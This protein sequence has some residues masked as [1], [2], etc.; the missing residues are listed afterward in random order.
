MNLEEETKKTKRKMIIITLIVVFGFLFF[1]IILPLCL[2]DAFFTTSEKYYILNITE[3]NEEKVRS[4]IAQ[5][6][7]NIGIKQETIDTCQ[8]KKIE[9]FHMFPDGTH[10][11]LFCK[12]QVEVSF[13]I[14]KVGEDVLQ[15]YIREHGTTEIRKRKLHSI[16][17]L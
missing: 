1:L 17:F 9:F 5:E 6:S 2:L 12:N 10:Y 16:P 13:G 4:L 8:M 14:D 11:T 7:S 15:S 3:E